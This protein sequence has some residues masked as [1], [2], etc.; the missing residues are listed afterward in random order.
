MLVLTLMPVLVLVLVLVP[1]LMLVPV[2]VLVPALVLQWEAYI[3]PLCALP[4]DVV[5]VPVPVL[6]LA[7]VRRKASVS[8]PL[9]SPAAYTRPPLQ[10]PWT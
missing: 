7:L 6:A 4:T 2:L 10:R 5:P 3:T 8:A 9:L 1:V